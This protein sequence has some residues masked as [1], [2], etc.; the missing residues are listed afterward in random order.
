MKTNI[1]FLCTSSRSTSYDTSDDVELRR[2]GLIYVYKL[3]IK[4]NIYIILL[5]QL[6]C[7]CVLFCV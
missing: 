3:Q 1:I 2:R 6:K 4:V 5:M 7:Q